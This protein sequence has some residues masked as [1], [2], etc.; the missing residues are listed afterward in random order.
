MTE[1]FYFSSFGTG[2]F[3][4]INYTIPSTLASI[5]K[6]ET[7]VSH[8]AMYFAIQGLTGAAATALSTGIIWVQLKANN[9]IWLAPLVV[10]F[11]SFVSLVLTKFMSRKVSSIGKAKTEEEL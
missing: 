11:G 10:I 6:K 3:F 8:P 1:R 7:G 2:C 9:L 5:E 4:S